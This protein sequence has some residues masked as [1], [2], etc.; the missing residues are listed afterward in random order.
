M[1]ARLG[2]LRARFDR[3]D[4]APPVPSALREELAAWFAPSVDRLVAHGHVPRDLWA[5]FT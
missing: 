1:S 4:A 5:D 3:P 2:R